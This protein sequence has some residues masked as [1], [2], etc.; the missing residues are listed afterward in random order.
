MIHINSEHFATR[1]HGGYASLVS[2]SNED[3]FGADVYNLR[4]L[5]ARMAQT[6]RSHRVSW[7]ICGVFY[8]SF[9][10]FHHKIMLL[11]GE[12]IRYSH[13]FNVRSDSKAKKYV[14]LFAWIRKTFCR[15]TFISFVQMFV[16]LQVF[17]T[18]ATKKKLIGT[19]QRSSV[20]V[21]HWT[22]RWNCISPNW[23]MISICLTSFIPDP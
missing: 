3:V 2:C 9:A 23:N 6:F 10:L 14:N 16:Q 20:K 18:R 12:N 19:Q 13:L 8:V 1:L 11:W 22:W 7:V 21:S 17:D 15:T 5:I 4:F